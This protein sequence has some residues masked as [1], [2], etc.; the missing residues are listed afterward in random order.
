MADFSQ[1][2]ARQM[3]HLALRL[4]ASFRR[5][6][7]A[8]YESIEPNLKGE[9]SKTMGFYTRLMEEHDPAFLAVQALA[10]ALAVIYPSSDC[11]LVNLAEN[12]VEVGAAKALETYESVL[13]ASHAASL[14]RLSISTRACPFGKM[15]EIYGRD[16]RLYQAAMTMLHRSGTLNDLQLRAARLLWEAPN[17]LNIEELSPEVLERAAI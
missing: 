7:V 13:A 11:D 12:D 14:V 8:Y 15:R 17:K 2:H 16:D 10:G 4:A 6:Q 1:N 9:T 5:W 3:A